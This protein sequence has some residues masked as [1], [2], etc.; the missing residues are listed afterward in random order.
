MHEVPDKKSDKS[1][2]GASGHLHTEA[3]S[4]KRCVNMSKSC[5]S[6]EYKPV[7]NSCVCFIRDFNTM[8]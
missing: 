5:I 1:R 4:G 3:V 7:Q 6:S 8:C 2:F